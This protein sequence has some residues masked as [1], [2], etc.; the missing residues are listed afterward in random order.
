MHNYDF[1]LQTL[2]Q[3]VTPNRKKH[4]LSVFET[5]KNIVWD[6]NCQSLLEKAEIAAL[7]HD[8]SKN[9]SYTLHLDIIKKYALPVTSEDLETPEVLHAFTG[10]AVA[11]NLFPQLI[12][13]EIYNAIFYH[14]TGKADMS[15]LEKILFLADYIEPDRSYE[16]CMKVRH[17]YQQNKEEKNGLDQAVYLSLEE[18]VDHLTRNREKINSRTIQAK[19]FYEHT[20][21]E[22]KN[23]ETAFIERNNQHGKSTF[24]ERNCTRDCKDTKR[25][26]C[27]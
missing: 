11:K 12:D 19:K 16:S 22:L 1:I 5:A 2:D 27:D 10:A 3:Y 7:L 9:F 26:K 4:I 15:L 18:T 21:E 24:P 6:Q 25:E 23:Q 14:C 13:E 8:I 20:K 17:Y